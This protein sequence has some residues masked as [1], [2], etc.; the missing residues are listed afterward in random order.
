MRLL[1][2]L[3]IACLPAAWPLLAAADSYVRLGAGVSRTT[4]A[5]DYPGNRGNPRFRDTDVAAIAGLGW[6]FNRWLGVEGT[7]TG[8][9]LFFSDEAL[10]RDA[11]AYGYGLSA[12]ASLPVSERWALTARY[13][14]WR[15][16]LDMQPTSGPWSSTFSGSDRVRGAGVEFRAG[17]DAVLNLAFDD[18]RME[19][20]KLRLVTISLHW[21]LG[22]TQS[23]RE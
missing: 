10:E 23:A 1:L 20:I 9:D 14:T 7:L 6:R 8:T 19:N 4:A 12:I 16:R 22:G 11:N 18:Y 17:P 3:L 13:G 15:W 21:L 5:G 2:P